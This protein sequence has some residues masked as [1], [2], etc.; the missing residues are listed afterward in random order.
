MRRV[1]TDIFAAVLLALLMALGLG[2]CSA[3]PVAPRVAHVAVRDIPLYIKAARGSGSGFAARWN[4]KVGILTAWHVVESQKAEADVTGNGETARA[5]FDRVGVTDVAWSER[6]FIPARWVTL[7]IDDPVIG[8]MVDAWGY[9]N[10]GLHHR[11]GRVI[12]EEKERNRHMAPEGRYMRLGCD[13]I[14]GM[15]GGPVL[16]PAGRAVGVICLSDTATSFKV[17][18]FGQPYDV[19]VRV[20]LVAA[21]IP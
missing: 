19:E 20:E 8:E 21:D 15:S 3:Q 12:R 14:Q 10:G 4:G 5:K 9:A 11:Q 13:V 7:D 2:A 16:N 6:T 18:R 17:N 1:L